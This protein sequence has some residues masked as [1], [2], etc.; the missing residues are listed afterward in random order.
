[1]D[2]RFALAPQIHRLVV[3]NAPLQDLEKAEELLVQM[4]DSVR[5]PSLFSA[6]DTAFHTLLVKPPAI[7][8]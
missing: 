8:Y 2:T 4:E 1:M 6:L 5:D 3:L 7:G